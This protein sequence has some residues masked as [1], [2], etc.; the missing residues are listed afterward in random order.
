MI[1]PNSKSAAGRIVIIGGKACSGKST[2]GRALAAKLDVPFLSMGNFSRDYAMRQFG[3]NIQEFQDYCLANPH[4]DHELDQAFCEQCRKAA[5]DKGAVVDFRLGGHF[6]PDA[7]KV[8]L[9]ISDEVA[10]ARGKGRGD[11]TP[12]TLRKR[13]EAMRDRLKATYGYDFTDLRNYDHVL[14]V[15]N[16]PVH[17][18][19]NLIYNSLP[20]P[21][22]T[23]RN[24]RR[25]RS[26]GM[27]VWG[28][29]FGNRASKPWY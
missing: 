14:N 17:G 28:V 12:E 27:G 7:H 6:F 24:L 19:T 11:E 13:N 15:D 29:D 25:M 9:E 23:T 18:L 26:R 16:A 10:A 4:L 3:M 22:P 8:C 1:D 2:I 5:A 21:W 20:D